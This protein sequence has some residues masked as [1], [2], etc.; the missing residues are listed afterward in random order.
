MSFFEK[1][2]H[3]F[4]HIDISNSIPGSFQPPFPFKNDE[5]K[6]VIKKLKN[7]LVLLEK[8]LLDNTQQSS[9]IL[10]NKSDSQSKSPE[11]F[12]KSWITKPNIDNCFIIS[13]PKSQTSSPD[14]TN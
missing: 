4:P 10:P 11:D 12:N 13:F 5:Q 14:F 1:L 8:Y 2:F 9:P 6:R 3:I 7:H